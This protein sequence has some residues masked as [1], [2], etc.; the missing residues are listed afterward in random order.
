[1]SSANGAAPSP[2]MTVRPVRSDSRPGSGVDTGSAVDVAAELD[3]LRSRPLA[4]H[5]DV[6]TRVHEQLQRD[7]SSV[8]DA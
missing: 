8:D 7:L 4:E 2:D 3:A 1:M 5:P 6:F